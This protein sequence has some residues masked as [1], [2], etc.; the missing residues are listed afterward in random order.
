MLHQFVVADVQEQLQTN[1]VRVNKLL[2][3]SKD[4]MH[5]H[6]WL[7]ETQKTHNPRH[8]DCWSMMGWNS[9]CRHL[10]FETERNSNRVQS[11][12]HSIRRD[13][14]LRVKQASMPERPAI[15]Q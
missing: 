6:L 11:T 15:L 12:R 3:A 13:D 4:S 7:T 1:D 2:L 10:C 8:V 14:Y 9:T 5:I